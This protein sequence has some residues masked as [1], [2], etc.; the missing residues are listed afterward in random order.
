ML[1]ENK[2]DNVD[3]ARNQYLNYLRTKDKHVDIN[4]PF[5]IYWF[6]LSAKKFSVCSFDH[7]ILRLCLCFLQKLK[8]YKLLFS[9]KTINSIYCTNSFRT[10][11]FIDRNLIKM[12]I[13]QN[14]AFL[15]ATICVTNAFIWPSMQQIILRTVRSLLFTNVYF[16]FRFFL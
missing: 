11:F 7:M 3:L 2:T 16:N 14:E 9:S 12:S 10:L 1:D 8:F 6:D 5:N 13:T 15:L 4:F